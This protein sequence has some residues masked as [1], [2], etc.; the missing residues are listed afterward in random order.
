MKRELVKRFENAHIAFNIGN[1]FSKEAKNTECSLLFNEKLPEDPY[2]NY[3]TKIDVDGNIAAFVKHVET[4]FLKNKSKP[5]FYIMPYTRPKNLRKTLAKLGY[6]IFTIDAW[7]FID[8]GKKIDAKKQVKIEA[9]TK[10]EI[11]EFKQV[12]NEVYMKGEKDDP[13]TGLSYLYG[14]FLERRFIQ[15]KNNCKTESFAA[16]DGK[17][18]VGTIVMAHDE[19]DACLYALAVLPRYRKIG[20]GS[21]LLAACT[22][23]AKKLNLENLFLQTKKDSRNEKIFKKLGFKTKF[24]AEQFYKP[25]QK[26]K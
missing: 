9:I 2:L 22:G 5:S 24:V 1:F 8:I 7:M 21:A 17:K 19:K 23:R 12:F 15:K 6:R 18:I 25:R 11:S 3:A 14:E 20:I 4:L 13:Y 26:C 16:I 10:N